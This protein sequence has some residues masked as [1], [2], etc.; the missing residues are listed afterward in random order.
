MI[1]YAVNPIAWSNDD[2]PS[3]GDHIPLERCL[4][5]AAE[6]GFTG[7]EKGRKMPTE[8]RALRAALEPH[9]L[10]FV[11]GWHSLELLARGVDAEK[12]AIDAHLRLLCEMGCEVCILCETSDAVYSDPDTPLSGRP[13]LPESEWPAFAAALTEIARH[14]ADRGPVPV[15]HHHLGT[16]VQSEA[17]IDRLL[18]LA[19]D[20]LKLLLDTG[21]A[22]ASGAEPGALAA[23]HAGRV[24]HLHFKNVRNAVLHEATERD[25]SFLDAVRAGVFTVPGDAEG[26]IDFMPVLE[27]AAAV[28]YRG[29]LVIEAEQDPKRRDPRTYQSMGLA[30]LKAMAHDAGLDGT[31]GTRP[32]RDSR[33]E[34]LRAGKVKE[35]S[36]TAS[37]FRSGTP[38]RAALR[39]SCPGSSRP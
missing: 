17:E 26:G 33:P 8:A 9:G 15:Y 35:R 38:A 4:R 12:R 1:R 14:V 25:W 16:V 3:L 34:S 19:G 30:A 2:D 13:V 11:S 20:E 5:E 22:A 32:S 29:W 28:A 18:G 27:A 24:R 6:I 10:D 37:E 23:R 7:I 31:R 36:E 21:H 39:A